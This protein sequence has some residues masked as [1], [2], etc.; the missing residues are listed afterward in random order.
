MIPLRKTESPLDHAALPPTEGSALA[1]RLIDRSTTVVNKL[2]VRAT[3][4]LFVTLCLALGLGSFY[5]GLAIN[6]TNAFTMVLGFGVVLT[7]ALGVGA[8]ASIQRVQ[9][10]YPPL[11]ARFGNWDEL[12]SALMKSPM[13]AR[14]GGEEVRER[15][16]LFLGVLQ[17]AQWPCLIP[18]KLWMTHVD[19]IGGSGG[20]K[21]YR[22]VVP[23][24][25]QVI[26]RRS[27]HVVYIDLKGDSGVLRNL[28]IEAR[29]ARLSCKW[30]SLMSLNS[31]Y[32]YNPFLQEFLAA[33]TV[34][35]RVQ[36]LRQALGLEGG[37]GHGPSYY[38][39]VQEIRV[40]H[41]VQNHPNEIRSFRDMLRL[42]KQR[43]DLKELGLS[44]R[45]LDNSSHVV[46]VIDRLA[47]HDALN[48]MPGDGTPGAAVDAAISTIEILS[49]PGVTVFDLPATLQP[50]TARVVARLVA[51]QIVAAAGVHQGPRVPVIVI[52]DEAQEAL[53]R[54]LATLIKQA[55]DRSISLWLAH[56][57]LSDLQTNDYDFTGVV[58]GNTSVK[59]AFSARDTLGRDYIA[60]TA[61]EAIR[62]LSSVG[63][64]VTQTAEHGQNNQ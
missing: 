32:I 46:A 12:T 29:R 4:V 17:G 7:V 20:G 1:H 49:R 51:Q 13:V 14:A 5:L 28:G 6:E 61:G 26:R 9:E 21:T 35:E 55:R 45:D 23:L 63:H 16:H 52:I 36:I 8:I 64:S 33:L 22:A 3:V 10:F 38:S 42:L 25:V 50:T 24:A 30:F 39:A 18:L 56:Q 2:L 40:K 43:V 58:Q 41:V 59:I 57:N 62:T 11:A 60:R 31:S 47:E 27:I 34:N 54:G 53:A 37:E 19:I 48:A 15:D 44:K